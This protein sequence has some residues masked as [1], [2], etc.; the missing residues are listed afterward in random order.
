MVPENSPTTLVSIMERSGEHS[1]T[2]MAGMANRKICETD[3]T[4]S[5]SSSSSND[6][7]SCTLIERELSRSSFV[8]SAGEY[9]LHFAD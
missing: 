9:C 7:A 4:M 3:G 5:L 6:E 8:T 1:H 2:P